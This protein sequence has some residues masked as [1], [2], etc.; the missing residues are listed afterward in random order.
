M[1]K[2]MEKCARDALGLLARRMARWADRIETKLNAKVRERDELVRMGLIRQGNKLH[3]ALDSCASERYLGERDDYEE[4]PMRERPVMEGDELCWDNDKG[5]PM[6][7]CQ[8][9]K[10]HHG[11]RHGYK[12][13]GM[14]A[15]WGYAEREDES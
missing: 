3:T 4:V 14:S 15:A 13:G 1:K 12:I 7:G 9:P 2:Y 6:I 5:W 10:G 11:D 8:K